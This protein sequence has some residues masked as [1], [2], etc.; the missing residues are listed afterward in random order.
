[1]FLGRSLKRRTIH[2]RDPN[3]RIFMSTTTLE[4]FFLEEDTEAV[5]E[6]MQEKALECPGCGLPRDETMAIEATF[7]YAAEPVRCH[8]CAARER[9]ASPFY[10][11]VAG[12]RA[13]SGGISFLIK[14]LDED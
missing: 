9:A 6:Y 12:G 1:M 2:H 5:L 7:G 4:P 13:D 11:D 8:A 14:K 3:G 10:K